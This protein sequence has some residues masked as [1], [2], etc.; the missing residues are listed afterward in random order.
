MLVSPY[1]YLKQYIDKNVEIFTFNNKKYEGVFKGIDIYANI[2][3]H[4]IVADK[5][6]EK[7]LINGVNVIMINFL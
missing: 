1:D 2:Y 5:I 4:Q 3:L 6:E 7:V